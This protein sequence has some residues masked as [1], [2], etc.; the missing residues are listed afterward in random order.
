[1]KP[2]R[3]CEEHSCECSPPAMDIVKT[4]TSSWRQGSVD[5]ELHRKAALTVIEQNL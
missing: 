3:V 1:M 4:H 2:R 5:A